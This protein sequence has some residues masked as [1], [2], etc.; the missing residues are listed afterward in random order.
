[1]KKQIFKIIT[2]NHGHEISFSEDAHNT[3]KEIT[4]HVFEFIEW[5]LTETNYALL[6]GEIS[7]KNTEKY[8]QYWFNKVKNE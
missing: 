6:F 4:S 5:L 1:M 2:K 8:Y 3:A 7:K